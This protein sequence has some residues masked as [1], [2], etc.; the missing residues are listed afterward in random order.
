[1]NAIKRTPTAEES[2]HA[3]EALN[4]IKAALRTGRIS[5]DNAKHFALPY[6]ATFNEYS[7]AKAKERGL[8][9]KPITFAGFMR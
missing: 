1:M 5:Y 3:I 4:S 8:T 7:K 2:H 6:L 9:I